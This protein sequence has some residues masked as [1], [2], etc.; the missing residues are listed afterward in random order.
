MKFTAAQIDALSAEYVLGTLHGPARRRFEQLQSERGDVRV[1]V[2][3]WERHLN[4]L[5]D[6][7]K[8]APP[9]GRVWK[10]IRERIDSTTERSASTS[11]WWRSFWLAVPAAAAIAW[12][13]LSLLPL[14]P[15]LQVAVFA[16]TNA[17]ALWIVSANLDEGSVRTEAVSAVP[18]ASGTS[19]ELWVLPA[20]GPPQ[21]LGL[22]PEYP[23]AVDVTISPALRAALAGSGRL[24]I[25]VE[26]AGGSTTG[27]PTGPV[28]YQASLLRI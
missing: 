22:L 6:G 28:V 26:P 2:W 8:S 25:S 11:S 1:A 20:D 16:D 12:L 17:D 14:Q 15:Q 13:A 23:N 7:L 21:S 3:R 5:S 18:L 27:L 9:P 10:R 19:F 4:G 24:A